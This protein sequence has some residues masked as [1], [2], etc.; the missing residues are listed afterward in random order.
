MFCLS[1]WVGVG[2]VG[3]GLGFLLCVSACA[4]AEGDAGVVVVEGPVV[5]HQ[6]GDHGGV[7]GAGD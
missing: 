7:F 3:E 2:V 4:E 6:D 1:G 5:V